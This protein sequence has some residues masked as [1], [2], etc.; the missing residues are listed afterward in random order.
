MPTETVYGLAADA[1]NPSAVARIYAVKGR[2]ADHPLIVHFSDPK[3]INSWA[4]EV[5]DYATYLAKAFW[6]GPMTLVLSR[7]DLA[8]DFITGGQDTVA[9]RVPRHPVALKLLSE[10]EQLGGLGVAAPSA[11]RFGKVSPTNS[12]AVRAEL[13]DYLDAE[14]MILEGGD[15][16]VGIESTIIDCT[17]E[18]PK[19]LRLGAI[20][21]EMITQATG[22]SVSRA[23]S[24][25][26]V[27]GSLASH[28]APNAKV[29]LDQAVLPGE[30]LIALESEPT[31]DSVIRLIA[32]VDVQG[33]AQQL[34][35]A[36]R[37]ADALG[38][39]RVVAITPK[40][41]GLAEAIRDRL[42]RASY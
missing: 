42:Q 18:S 30:G 19:L 32:P 25:I 14:D 39:R 24:T 5:P 34:Y 33:Y 1:T 31:P 4:A 9:V 16:E 27:S 21:A 37:Q 20:T 38:L 12:S 11:N 15:S 13:G 6:P 2:P 17:S 28:Y 8:G 22:L 10:F 26:R 41:D 40:G 29:V 7:T 36:L 23:P 3:L 35:F